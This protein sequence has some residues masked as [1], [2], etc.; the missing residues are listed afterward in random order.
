MPRSLPIALTWSRCC[1]VSAATSWRFSS[2]APES[3]NW[4]PGSSDTVAI[5]SLVRPPE[6]DDVVAFDDRQ[7]AVARDQRFED[8]ADAARAVVGNRAQVVGVEDDLLVL[9]ADAPFRRRLRSGR[10]P[11]D[12]IGARAHDRGRRTVLAGRH[13]AFLMSMSLSPHTLH[14]RGFVGVIGPTGPVGNKGGGRGATPQD[15]R[16]ATC[17]SPR[18]PICGTAAARSDRPARICPTRVT[19][20]INSA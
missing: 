7:P 12:E 18:K 10:D 16:R 14:A 4:P 17:G 15:A 19:G 13:R 9:G 8:R 2:G 5:G 20:Q 3:S 6:R 1:C 11:V